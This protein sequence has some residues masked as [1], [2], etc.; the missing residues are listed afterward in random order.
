MRLMMVLILALIVSSCH[1]LKDLQM[2]PEDIGPL[3]T[4]EGIVVGSLR[5]FAPNY[6][7]FSFGVKEGPCGSGYGFFDFRS[8]TWGIGLSVPFHE[9]VFVTKMPAGQYC[10]VHWH[11]DI[12]DRECFDLHGQVGLDFTVQPGEVLYIGSWT[13]RMPPAGEDPEEQLWTEGSPGALGPSDPLP[14]ILAA[15]IR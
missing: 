4:D 5:A 3:D 9:Q 7:H 12:P 14:Q 6:E 2:S 10:L 15:P 1:V 8:T 13:V 11:H